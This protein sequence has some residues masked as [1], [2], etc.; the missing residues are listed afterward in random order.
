MNGAKYDFTDKEI[1]DGHN[2]KKGRYTG[3]REPRIVV[4]VE[5]SMNDDHN[6]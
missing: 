2:K 3:E 4:I 5:G 6:L 1:K